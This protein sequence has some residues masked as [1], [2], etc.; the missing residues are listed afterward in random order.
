M[1]AQHINCK[2]DGLARPVG[3][4]V[5]MAVQKSGRLAEES[6]SLLRN[7]GLHVDRSKD[8]LF[9]RI[10]EL[11]LDLLL[12]RDDDI[13]GFVSTGI[14]DLGIVGENVFAELKEAGDGGFGAEILERLGFSLCRLAIAAQ[15]DSSVKT[16]SDLDRATIATS[17]P[18]LLKRFLRANGISAKPL[19]MTGSVEV[20]PRLRIADAVCDIVSSGATLAANGLRELAVVLRSEALLI[21]SA[22]RLSP[23]KEETAHRLLERMRGALLA[24]D[25]KYIMLNAPRVAV[26]QISRLLP[27]CDAPTIVDLN[28]DDMVAIQAVC[29]ETVFWETLE[30]IRAAGGRAILV[31]PIEKMMA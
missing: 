7:C 10:K 5:R 21:R 3:D 31:L 29:K 24:E 20:A 15:E 27:G 8:Q 14:C 26:E 9:C 30:Q 23:G 28:T 25:S 4:R 13:P 18:H 2:A 11:P 17:Y 12:V 6:I 16:I 22:Q 1:I 19:L